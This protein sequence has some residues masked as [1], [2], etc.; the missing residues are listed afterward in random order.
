MFCD[1][2]QSGLCLEGEIAKIYIYIFNYYYYFLLM[3]SMEKGR[4]ISLRTCN[5]RLTYII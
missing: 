4:D 2:D 5:I 3:T 1:S